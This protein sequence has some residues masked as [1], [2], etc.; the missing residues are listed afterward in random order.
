MSNST[1]N[2]GT[3]TKETYI[4]G[5]CNIGKD[6]VNRRR[7]AALYAGAMVLVVIATITITHADKLWRFLVFFPGTSFAIGVQQWSSKFCVGF[8]LRGVFN[9]KELGTVVPIEQQDMLKA[10]RAKAIKMI[11]IGVIGGLL[12]TIAF[13]LVP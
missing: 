13:Y 4:P 8:G 6:E 3:D 2:K 11:T 12:I 1:I 9:F 10:D 7:K 5:V